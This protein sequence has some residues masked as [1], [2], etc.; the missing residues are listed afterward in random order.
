MIAFITPSVQSAINSNAL[1]INTLLLT[2]LSTQATRVGNCFFPVRI[3]MNA[4]WT[5]TSTIYYL[6]LQSFWIVTFVS[7][8]V[9]SNST[10]T[11]YQNPNNLIGQVTLFPN[12]PVE[13]ALTFSPVCLSQVTQAR[14]LYLDGTFNYTF[15]LP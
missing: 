10:N 6:S 12:L 13:V 1:P 3:L 14:L 15:T 7:N 4:S 9:I 8:T 2:K 11:S 5:G